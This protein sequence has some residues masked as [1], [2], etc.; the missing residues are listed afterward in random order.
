MVGDLFEL[1]KSDCG[2]DVYEVSSRE[3]WHRHITLSHRALASL[4]VVR[5][6][7]GRAVQKKVGGQIKLTVP[8]VR[9]FLLH[10]LWQRVMRAELALRSSEC[11]RRH[12]HRARA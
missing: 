12:Q 6:R 3:G 10:V 8:E 9:K 11:R 7:A 1:A 4:E 2:L 5:R